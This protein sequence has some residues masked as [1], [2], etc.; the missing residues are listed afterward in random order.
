[1]TRTLKG[2]FHSVKPKIRL[3]RKIV[4]VYVQAMNKLAA[5][6]RVEAI[7]LLRDNRSA[8]D[9]ARQIGVAKNTA[10]SLRRELLNESLC[11]NG[12]RHCSYP[13][14][15]RMTG[16]CLLPK[17]KAQKL[18]KPVELP[19]RELPL[20]PSE[21]SITAMTDSEIDECFKALRWPDGMHCPRCKTPEPYWV[22]REAKAGTYR[23]RECEYNFS[24][25]SGTPF[26]SRKV[27]LR[28]IL[29]F[30]SLVQWSAGDKKIHR[31]A[32]ERHVSYKIAYVLTG[33][34]REFLG[35]KVE[36]TSVFVG[37][38]SNG[39][40]RPRP[41]APRCQIG[42]PDGK[43][44][45]KECGAVKPSE[46]FALKCGIAGEWGLRAA[47][48][49]DCVNRRSRIGQ[50]ETW[51]AKK[52]D[53]AANL[54]IRSARDLLRQRPRYGGQWHD[55]GSWWTTQNKHDL[56]TLVGAGASPRKAADILGRSPTSIAWYARDLLPTLPPE[57]R[58][59]ITPKRLVVPATPRLLVYPFLPEM[60][61]VGDTGAELVLAVNKVVPSY[62]P[63]DIRA[64]IAQ[65]LI[66]DILAGDITLAD[67]SAAAVRKARHAMRTTDFNTLSFEDVPRPDDDRTFL[68]TNLPPGVMERLEW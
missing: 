61:K 67:L 13:A 6:R 47:V 54:I 56:V 49:K 11:P 38:M 66:L 43:R 23:C 55:T 52:A 60:P 42:I 57:W 4:I 26:A 68:G 24:L 45:C 21:T 37:Y 3:T 41:A 32:Q 27:S 58:A 59:L 63:N 64:D 36:G 22:D 29:T 1:L 5:F 44:C 51:A 8:R 15:C 16:H 40:L 53:D 17:P 9:V 7:A 20:L 14:T 19:P 2:R 46:R 35:G 65:E 62:L 31:V 39:R 33:K 18:P 50:K 25:T 34:A 30:L 48:C 10:F 28:L 12:D